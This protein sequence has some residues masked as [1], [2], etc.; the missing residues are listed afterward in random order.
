MRSKH[1]ETHGYTANPSDTAI[2]AFT[3]GVNM[4]MT[5][6]LYRQYLPDAV[7]SGK[8]SESVVNDMVRP[9]L[10]AKY[11]LGLFSHPYVDMDHFKQVTGS[12]EQRAGVEKAAEATAVLLRNEA[13][14]LPLSK[15]LRSIAVLGPLA[16]SKVD[17]LGSWSIHGDRDAVVTVAQGIREKLPQARVDV[18]LGVEIERGSPTIFDE[19]FPPTKLTLTTDAARQAE[20]AHAL[21]LAR[22]A[23]ISVLV[24][25]E[26]QTMNGESASRAS[27]ALPGEQE[28]LLEAV[29]ALGKP[30]V[31]VLM[32][33][34][35]LDITWAAGH[36]PAIL[37]IWYPGSEGG[38]AVANLLFGEANPSGHLPV[39]WPR[40]AGQEPMF[41]NGKLP[42]NPENVAQRYWDLS[43][44][45]LYP[46]GYGLSYSD[47]TLADLKL[48]SASVT[49]SGVVRASV[50]LTNHSD[51]PGAQVVQMY[52]HQ[53]SGGT[54]RPARELK[55][56]RKVT[57]AAHATETVTLDLLADDLSYWSASLRH[58]TLDPGPFDVW[59]GTDSTAA[60]HT[61]F[62]LNPR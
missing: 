14:T 57:L 54:T 28:R 52:T 55:A 46:F 23:D 37:N 62:T 3:A 33:G 30:V 1:L 16:D 39:T 43:S 42:M 29:T 27:L 40:S 44:E 60:L 21:A 18:S 24:L 41:Y 45:P 50:T 8:V 22:A 2:R 5:S 7:G 13:K 61:T 9:I 49:P 35:P 4:E 56:F 58:R 36:V 10:A 32:T 19:Q 25:G 15:G 53:R 20:F 34:R 6:T 38:H 26:A 12:A 48:A 11:R 59:V 47:I 17:T 31:L 51:I